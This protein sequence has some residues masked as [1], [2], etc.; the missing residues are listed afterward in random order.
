MQYR[1]VLL[2]LAAVLLHSICFSCKCGHQTNVTPG[3]H[4]SQALHAR[5][6]QAWM[7]V[8]WVHRLA[9]LLRRMLAQSKCLDTHMYGT[10]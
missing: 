10:M 3:D 1:H 2:A 4:E 5:T 8:G 7:C 6:A 9:A